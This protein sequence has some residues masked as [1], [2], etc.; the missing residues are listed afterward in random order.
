M[1]IMVCLTITPSNARGH[2][3]WTDGGSHLRILHLAIDAEILR[4]HQ[5]LEQVVTSAEFLAAPPSAYESQMCSERP[6][7]AE[8]ASRGQS[9][10]GRSLVATESDC[11]MELEAG[12]EG[13]LGSRASGKGDRQR[14]KPSL[15]PA[16]LPQC[17]YNR[18]KEPR[19]IC[20]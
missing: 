5:R 4:A 8:A 20:F 12:A 1:A 19:G 2:E 6:D 11:T 7:S 14:E 17:R 9:G 3:A 10:E 13:K 16:W 18:G 15:S